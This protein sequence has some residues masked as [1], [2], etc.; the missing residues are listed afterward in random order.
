MTSTSLD[1]L[2]AGESEY[3]RLIEH[4]S[5]PF[6]PNFASALA[7]QSKGD[8]ESGRCAVI[9]L[10]SQSGK[11]PILFQSSEELRIY[12]SETP[13][14]PEAK[15]EHEPRRRL[16]I[17]EDLPR[18][19]VSVLGSRLRIPPSFFAGH[20]DDP[21]SSTFNHRNPLERYT[22]WQF[23]LRYSD[24]HR[25]EVDIPQRKTSRIYAYNANV[26]RYLFAYDPDGPLY[27]E[28]RSSHILSFWSSAIGAEG[29]WD[30][31]LLVDPP[32]RHDVRCLPSMQVVPVRRQLRDESS[33]PRDY[34]Y[35]EMST[36]QELPKDASAWAASHTDPPKF[37]SMF[38]DTLNEF[39]SGKRSLEGLDDPRAAVELPRKLVIA[40]LIS[41][42]RRRYMNLL[43]LQSAHAKKNRALEP[44]QTCKINY[45]ANFS[46]GA[47]SRWHN[48]Y[49]NFLI[50]SRAAM[51]EVIR[52][53]QE[54]MVALGV[55]A[56]HGGA[57]TPDTAGAAAPPQWEADGWASVMDQARV[58]DGLLATLAAA[59]VQYMTIQEAR[60]SGANAQSLSRIT[61]LT[62]LF[63]PLSTIAG[64]FSMSDDYL[65]GR[66]RAWVF[67]VVSVP[68]LLSLAYLYWRQQ[69]AEAVAERRGNWMQ[70]LERGKGRK[71]DSHV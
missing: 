12:L 9:E 50:G 29:S 7:R 59:Y 5:R 66:P 35:P 4:Q 2:D 3:L 8:E 30:A 26:F 64:I 24:S 68:C 62:M 51:K 16:F 65:P 23:R 18:N 71:D 11:H 58:V 52:E 63:V 21:G 15:A 49:F 38:N 31:L 43:R 6:F 1:L 27:D 39:A 67:W 33:M 54:N 70:V 48:D 40:M 14:P 56:R 60:V 34:L 42:L 10:G 17:L 41:F 61:V 25:A 57:P 13:S 45:L 32:L 69:L 37:A 44:N 22:P 20:Y 47:L 28:M 19:W 53:V 46:G 36:L 55:A